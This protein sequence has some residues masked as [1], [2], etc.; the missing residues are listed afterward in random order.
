[1]RE[2]TT[3]H[4]TRAIVGTIVDLARTLGMRTLA[5]GVE[6]PAQLELLRLARCDSLQGYLI[7][8]P[9]PLFELECLLAKWD[10]HAKPAR[11]VRL[12]AV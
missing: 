2:L 9:M 5:E 3:R 11:P 10:E 7:A 1:V 12:Q 6:E 4:D 8:R